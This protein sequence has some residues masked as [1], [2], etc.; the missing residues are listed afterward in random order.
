MGVYNCEE[1][2]RTVSIVG[3]P[4]CSIVGV[5]VMLM[6]LLDLSILA[7]SIGVRMGQHWSF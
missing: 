3:V 4:V 2:A 5:A 7:H 1:L 6:L